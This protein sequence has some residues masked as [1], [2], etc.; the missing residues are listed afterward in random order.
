MGALDFQNG[1]LFDG[2]DLWADERSRFL[3]TDFLLG[4]GTCGLIS[5]L[6]FQNG[7]LVGGLGLVGWM[8][9]LDFSKRT[10]V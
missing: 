10:S 9:A 2:W 6:D 1:L 7:L 3:K 4:V 5:A 8:S